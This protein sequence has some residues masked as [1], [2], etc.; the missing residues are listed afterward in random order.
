MPAS[1]EEA[2]MHLEEVDLALHPSNKQ[3]SVSTQDYLTRMETRG[4]M[5]K[6]KWLACVGLCLAYTTSYQQNACTAAIV[7]SIDEKLGMSFPGKY[8][9]NSRLIPNRPNY[10]L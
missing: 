10:V 4:R 6:A 2:K 5:T 9:L 3:D 8:A 7:K 1:V